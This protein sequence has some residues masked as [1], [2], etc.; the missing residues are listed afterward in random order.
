MIVV[1]LFLILASG[2][3]LATGI[4][5]TSDGLVLAS[6]AVSVF[7]AAALFLG[8][9]QQRARSA[10]DDE[11]GEALAAEPDPAAEPRDGETSVR[12]GDTP[13]LAAGDAGVD[14]DH[15]AGRTDRLVANGAGSAGDSVAEGRL[16]DAAGPTAPERSSPTPDADDAAAGDPAGTELADGEQ[17][18]F[19]DLG[20]PADEPP[21]E[22]LLASEEAVLSHRDDEVLVVDGR[23]RYHLTGCPHLND[24]SS[25]PLPVAEAVELGFTPC[26]RCAV[27]T[28]LLG[29]VS[30]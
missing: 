7:A 18:D 12:Q 28:T 27:A 16:D 15:E 29:A 20:D 25:E 11:S 21:A 22:L 2:A 4:L 3:M 14:S 9:R 1:S 30:S 13:H 17:D 26:S 24:K 23:P 19:D 8:I 10:A 6:I 5:Q